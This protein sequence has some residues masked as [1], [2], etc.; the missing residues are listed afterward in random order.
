MP[1]SSESLGTAYPVESLVSGIRFPQRKVADKWVQHGIRFQAMLVQKIL[2]YPRKGGLR[3]CCFV[4]RF[5]KIAEA[6]R[7]SGRVKRAVKRC[8]NRHRQKPRDVF[9]IN[10]L[11][12][13]LPVTG[14]DVFVAILGTQ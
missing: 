11:D 2:W 9:Y 14:T 3:F 4:T 7:V 10:Q 12:R 5:E 13:R 6:K 1:T 8:S